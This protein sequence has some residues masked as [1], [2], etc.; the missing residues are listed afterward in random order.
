MSVYFYCRGI[1]FYISVNVLKEKTFDLFKN[2]FST[3]INLKLV[4]V[5]T[6]KLRLKTLIK[7]SFNL[8]LLKVLQLLNKEI[9]NWINAID[10]FTFINLCRELDIYLYK[11]LWKFVRRL[12]PRRYNSWIY[13]KYWKSFSGIYKFVYFDKKIG[14]FYFLKTHISY[15]K[16]SFCS[17]L[18]LDVACFFNYRKV[19][20]SLYKK[21]RFHLEGIK[22][23]LFIKQKG[24]CFFCFKPV[25]LYFSKTLISNFKFS[26]KSYPIQFFLIHTYC[27]K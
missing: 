7:S 8:T 20:F 3:L 12:H 14:R 5:Q 19:F 15:S 10:N 16:N 1:D 21:S 18:Q 24:L 2:C 26:Y 23:F 9:Y 11:L 27:F 22:R 6:Y 17:P 25:N 13:N 4:D